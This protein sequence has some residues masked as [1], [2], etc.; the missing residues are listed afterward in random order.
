MHVSLSFSL[1]LYTTLPIYFLEYFVE[2][3]DVLYDFLRLHF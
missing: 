1:T 2:I 3:L